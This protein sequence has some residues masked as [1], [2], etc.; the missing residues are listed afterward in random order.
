MSLRD[1]VT[2]LGQSKLMQGGLNL[3]GATDLA[4]LLASR[5]S[6]EK[7]EEWRQAWVEQLVATISFLTPG[8]SMNEQMQAFAKGQMV[9]WVKERTVEEARET[10]Q[11]MMATAQR[12]LDV[13][14]ESN[15]EYPPV[16]E[17]SNSEHIRYQRS[18]GE[19]GDADR[20]N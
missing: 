12:L 15:V 17:V 7:L 6:D 19:T 18:S 1:A 20:D 13:L 5:P 3:S 10:A 8:M 14:P 9:S 11:S 16:P 4:H 2:R